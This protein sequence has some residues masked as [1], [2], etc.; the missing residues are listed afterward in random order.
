MKPLPFRKQA[1][2]A[3][4]AVR[5]LIAIARHFSRE[6]R[7]DLARKRRYELEQGRF[8]TA[9]NYAS[10]DASRQRALRRAYM[11]AARSVRYH[12]GFLPHRL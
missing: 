8:S 2:G 3:A 12:T 5:E 7:K 6:R 1:E 11:D 4:H 10:L 9:A